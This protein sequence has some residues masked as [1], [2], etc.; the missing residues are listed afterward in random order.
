[1]VINRVEF[2]ACTSSNFGEIETYSQIEGV[3]LCD[4]D[5]IIIYQILKHIN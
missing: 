4:V 1:M 2:D 3:A 5:Q